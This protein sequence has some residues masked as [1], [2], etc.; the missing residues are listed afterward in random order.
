MTI[1]EQGS[2]S[3]SPYAIEPLDS[4][5]YGYITADDLDGDRVAY[6]QQSSEWKLIINEKIPATMIRVPLSDD[7]EQERIYVSIANEVVKKLPGFSEHMFEVQS[8][9]VT[10]ELKYTYFHR[11]HRALD[12]LSRSTITRLVPKNITSGE[13]DK[14]N[15]VSK[16][17]I[18]PS[19]KNR[20][21]LDG[22]QMNALKVIINAKPGLPVIVVG[23][24]GT[25]K[26]RL[27]ARA[28]YQILNRSSH[29]KP[30][31]VL[32]CAH[33]QESADSF[34]DSYF[35]SMVEDDWDVNMIR[36]IL[37]YDS[38]H[39]N[40]CYPEFRY[41]AKDI[42][43]ETVQLV[44]TTFGN[45]LHLDGMVYRGFFTHILMDE[46]AQT[47]EPENIAPLFLCGPETV[48]V[49]AGDHK[50]VSIDN[51]NLFILLNHL[52]YYFAGWSLHIGSW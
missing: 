1:N 20:L 34:I 41:M 7:K 14:E 29:F 25:G 33:H 10:F 47:R 21:F 31:R 38:D 32:V 18:H 11:L 19:F 22:S 9:K 48:V 8:V 45:A 17:G 5:R 50:Q 39:Y 52:T 3:P 4:V 28:A 16:F 26:T 15:Q 2:L 43:L 6:A 37:S 42:N 51:T 12:L 13:E 24:F 30:Y 46:G 35:G 49:I 23:S 44:V 40:N 36:M 27:L